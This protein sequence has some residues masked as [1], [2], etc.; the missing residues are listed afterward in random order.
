MP[1]D[2]P[3]ADETAKFESEIPLS[4][5]LPGPSHDNA[6]LD[7]TSPVAGDEAESKDGSEKSTG[8]GYDAFQDFLKKLR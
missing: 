8:D 1:S 5:L 6:D 2:E 3:L 4:Q 7:A